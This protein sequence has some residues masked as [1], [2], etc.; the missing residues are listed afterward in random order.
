MIGILKDEIPCKIVRDDV[1]KIGEGNVAIDSD[2]T[3]CL[4]R[5]DYF[6]MVRVGKRR[7]IAADP[8]EASFSIRRDLT[9][10]CESEPGGKA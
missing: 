2:K 8:G 4:I 10:Q 3:S 6:S 1:L 7:A 9:P 5:G